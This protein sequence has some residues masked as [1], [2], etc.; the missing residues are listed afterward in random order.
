LISARDDRVT[1]QK[2]GGKRITH[3][4]DVARM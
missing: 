4:L 1:L 3:S 2:P